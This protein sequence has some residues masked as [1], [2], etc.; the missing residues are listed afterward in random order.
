MNIIWPGN[1]CIICL[2]E[3]TLSK[4]H[5]IPDALGGTLTCAFLCR[6]CNSYLG[7]SV[8]AEAKTDPSIRIAIENLRSSIPDLAKGLTENQEF[9]SYG[10]GGAD[11]GVVRSGEFQVQSKTK[12]DGSLIQ[13]TDDARGSIEKNLRRADAS[14]DVVSEALRKFDKGEE[15]ERVKVAPGVEVIKWSIEKLE[16]DLSRSRLINP[17]IPLKIAYEFLAILMGTVIYRE[18]QEMTELRTVLLQNA[19][20]HGSFQVDRLNASEYK[21]FHGICFEG[22][23]PHARILIRLFGWLAFRVHFKRLAFGGPRVAY[24][25]YLDSGQDQFCE[26]PDNQDQLE[27]R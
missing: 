11:R 3:D 12:E 5:I 15:N 27:V 6:D 17:I 8:E 13:P 23:S 2:K 20:N 16:V 9:I 26:I 24:T 22:N 1:R 7:S 4:E 19:E 25:H 10:P 21:P 14:D 18:V